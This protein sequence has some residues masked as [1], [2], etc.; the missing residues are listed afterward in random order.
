MST[1]ATRPTKRVDVMQGTRLLLIS[2][3]IILG[4]VA[5]GS[6][7]QEPA[8]E[9]DSQDLGDVSD[10]SDS[11][12]NTDA[13]VDVTQTDTQDDATDTN[14]D[15]AVDRDSTDQAVEAQPDLPI[16]ADAAAP[17]GPLTIYAWNLWHNGLSEDNRAHLA[18]W[19][20]DIAF[21]L[22][23]EDLEH[24]QAL[25]E[26]Q[27]YDY[28]FDAS[29]G[30][31]TVASRFP[32]EGAEIIDPEGFNHQIVYVRFVLDQREVHFFQVHFRNPSSGEPAYEQQ[33]WE[34][35]ETLALIEEMTGHVSTVVLGDFNALSA[36]DGRSEFTYTTDAFVE[37]GYI[38]SYRHL[39]GDTFEATKIARSLPNERVDYVFVSSDLEDTLLEA[40]IQTGTS[41]PEHSDHRAIWVKLNFGL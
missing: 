5:C 4:A 37:A 13:R 29:A 23:S 3:G 20:P 15:I 35:D 6:D 10:A 32:Y 1:V 22:D 25:I 33:R 7:R 18:S 36:S 8:T 39:N 17:I 14:Q 30:G 21:L 12:T 28:S 24:H 11:D 27:S 2:L 38:D 41:Y 9:G 34:A 31:T 19:N 26:E 16:D 40:G